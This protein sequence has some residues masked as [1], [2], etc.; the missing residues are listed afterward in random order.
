MPDIKLKINDLRDEPSVDVYLDGEGVLALGPEACTAVGV[1]LIEL[2]GVA[3]SM[4]DKKTA[5]AA[6]AKL[7]RRGG[8]KRKKR[9]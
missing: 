1:K 7:D 6:V 9:R 2:A 8:N 4:R 3:R 5:A